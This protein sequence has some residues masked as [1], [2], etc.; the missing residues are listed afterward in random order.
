LRSKKI[1]VKQKEISLL[2]P[3]ENVVKETKK[4][5]WGEPTWFLFHTLAEKI[6]EEEFQNIRV[7]F[8][9]II[10][11]ICSNLPCP[12]CSTHAKKHLNSTNFNNIQTKQ[13]LKDFFFHFHNTVNQR[14]NYLLFDYQ[15][16]NEKYSNDEN[17]QILEKDESFKV[18]ASYLEQK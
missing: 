8:L 12:I 2:I 10:Y 18:I 15:N 1:N 13:Q 6:K 7:E 4:M 11:S 5:E 3:E 17:N 16:I 9:N 14:K